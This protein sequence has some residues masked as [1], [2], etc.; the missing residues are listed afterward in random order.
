M[1][2]LLEEEIAE[3]VFVAIASRQ[4]SSVRALHIHISIILQGAKR[5]GIEIEK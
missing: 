2:D 4:S 5:C 3:L 1:A